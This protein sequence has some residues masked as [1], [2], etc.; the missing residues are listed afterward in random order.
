MKF[1]TKYIK[2]DSYYVIF[3]NILAAMFSMFSFMILARTLS[4]TEFGQFETFLA[5]IV[6]SELI[7]RGLTNNALVRFINSNTNKE[8]D[9]IISSAL[10]INIVLNGIFTI[11]FYS[12]YFFYFK[13][14]NYIVL[15]LFLIYYPML[16]WSILPIS[17]V[18]SVLQADVKFKI[19]ALSNIFIP[20]LLFIAF[21]FGGFT[22]INSIMYVIYWNII[23]RLILSTFVTIKYGKY[24]IKFKDAT[25]SRIMELINFGKYNI[26]TNLSSNVLKSSDKILI[27][28]F[29]GPLY[30]AYWSIPTRI[31]ETID[32]PLRS[33][34]ATSFPKIT[35]MYNDG[36]TTKLAEYLHKMISKYVLYAIPLVLISLFIPSLFVNILGGPGF[37]KSYIIL[38]IFSIYFILLPFDR[39][40]GTTLT[41]INKPHLDTIK[42]SLMTAS[43]I[44]GD[45]IVLK[46]FD[47]IIWP[48]AVVT[49]VNILV[50]II[51]GSMLLK[52][53][54]KNFHIYKIFYYI[55]PQFKEM[56]LS[57]KAK[58]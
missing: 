26:L 31:T 53:Y 7:R 27:Q 38:Q 4:L 47:N 2:N 58:I 20:I 21:V 14:T 48:V 52:K 56:Y 15:N 1:I 35:K 43:N 54:I 29:L 37:E 57:I 11:L 23:S 25:L 33:S 19:L 45:I 51:I 3:G 46:Y 34:S 49:I 17:F 36:E 32:N 55:V 50:G 6:I 44:I 22:N 13:Y 12:L 24:F 5:F 10:Y 8:R 9:N 28:Y 18:R 16:M 39:F 42:V 41:A 40:I 30:V